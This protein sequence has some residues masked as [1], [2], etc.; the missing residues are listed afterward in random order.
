MAASIFIIIDPQNDFTSLNGD[1]AKRH[2]G[3]TQIVAAKENINRLLDKWDKENFII[4][5][6]DYQPHQFGEGLVMCIPGTTGHNLDEHLNLDDGNM[7]CIVKTDHSAFSSPAFR[8]YLKSREIDTLLVCGFLAEYCV[9]QTALDALELG[10]KVH[11]LD[12]C[13]GTGDDVQP[14]KQQM[15][16]EL[17][18]KGAEVINSDTYKLHGYSSE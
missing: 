4:I 14:R 17:Q 11:L 18:Q 3:I 5:K 1:Y 8:Q 9:K 12:D 2:S 6:S 15:L 16:Q 10:Y 13:I 7:T